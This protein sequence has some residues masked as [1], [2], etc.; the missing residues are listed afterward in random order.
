MKAYLST[1]NKINDGAKWPQSQLHQQAAGKISPSHIL[2]LYLVQSCNSTSITPQVSR[3]I[4]FFDRS[5]IKRYAQLI[6]FKIEP[7]I[8]V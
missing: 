2:L 5:S 4:H 3:V 7:L 1:G 6:A 8:F